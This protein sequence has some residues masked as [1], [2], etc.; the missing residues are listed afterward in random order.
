MPSTSLPSAITGRPSPTA[1][2]HAVGTPLTP[3]LD[4][5][6]LPAQHVG[7]VARRLDLLE[8]E[9]AVREHLVDHLLREGR[10]RVDEPRRLDL[11]PLEAR[12]VGR[13][14]ARGGRRRGGGRRGGRR[15]AR[16]RLRGGGAGRDGEREEGGARGGAGGRGREA[17]GGRGT[18]RT[19]RRLRHPARPRR[20]AGAGAAYRPA[21][22]AATGA[23]PGAH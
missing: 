2:T 6:P 22:D 15:R 8:A 21:A 19:P 18:G 4:A 1:P 20:R 23:P 12:R 10:E 3:G 16:R 7:E 17:H 9:L 13:G 14:E 11:E 5:E